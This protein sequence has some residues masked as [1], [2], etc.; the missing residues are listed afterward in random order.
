MDISQR[1]SGRR[2]AAHDL[3]LAFGQR[4]VGKEGCLDVVVGTESHVAVDVG[5]VEIAPVDAD[6]IAGLGE[7]GLLYGTC[8]HIFDALVDNS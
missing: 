6:A 8:L 4:A 2:L 5:H 1:G 3:V 7:D